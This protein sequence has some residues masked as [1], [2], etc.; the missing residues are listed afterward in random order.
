MR[1]VDVAIRGRGAVAM[2]LALALSQRGLQVALSAAAALPV[3]RDARWGDGD[4]NVA[5][6]WDA[7]AGLPS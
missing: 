4:R 3:W 5:A 1:T 7:R 2:S 6:P